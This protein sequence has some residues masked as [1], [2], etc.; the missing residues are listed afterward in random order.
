M[1][2]NIQLRYKWILYITILFITAVAESTVLAGVRLLGGAPRLLPFAVGV[3]AMFEGINGGAGAGLAAGIFADAMST[4]GEGFYTVIYVI[5]G[6]V[7]SVLNAFT[8]RKTFFV[9]LLF[10]LASAFICAVFYYVFFV[11][12]M[13]KGGF[14]AIFPIL[15][16][17]VCAT[18]LF[19]PIV[20]LLLY[21]VKCR[22]AVED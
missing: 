18:V 2:D 15:G 12:I 6:I 8:Y 11:L 19:T 14:G 21:A 13:G 22:F 20:Y 16:G 3:I 10:W 7:V 4:S 1:S 9:S 17:E 5:C